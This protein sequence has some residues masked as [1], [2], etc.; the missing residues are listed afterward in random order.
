MVNFEARPFQSFDHLE[1]LRPVRV[2]QNINVMGLNEKRGVA[3]PGDAN[4][5]V[6]KFGKLRRR[7]PPE[8]LT[9][10]KP[11]AGE[12]ITGKAAGRGRTGHA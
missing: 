1:P 6:T 9:K 3:D 4:L 7:R 8:R 11:D 2:D 5:A 10:R 12:K